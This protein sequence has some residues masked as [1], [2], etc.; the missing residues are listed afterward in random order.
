MEPISFVQIS[1]VHFGTALLSTAYGWIGGY[2]PHAFVLCSALPVAFA[3]AR[4]L[5][6]LGDD[7]PLYLVV[8]GD[9]TA[10]GYA[11]EFAVAHA[12][13]RTRPRIQRS[14]PGN[15]FGLAMPD[16]HLAA[17]P[18]NHDHWRGAPKFRPPPAYSPKTIRAQFRRT[19]WRKRWPSQGPTGVEL[20]GVDSNSGLAGTATN[21]FAK[22]AISTTEFDELDALL[23]ASVGS[24][25]VKAIVCHHSL[26]YAGGVFDARPLDDFSRER[27]LA[28]AAQHRVSAILTGHTHDFDFTR[29]DV[30]DPRSAANI[31]AVWELR[32]AST[33]QGPPK[34]ARQGF[35]LHRIGESG[36]SLRWSSWRYMWNGTHFARA[37]SG[38]PCHEFDIV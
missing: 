17:V 6:G 27:L 38:K 28:I 23:T 35:L 11:C 36:A 15:L 21:T 4:V 19:P 37:D 18:G 34:P 22:G 16:D 29:R 5:T 14:A 33:L 31:R 10:G 13:L 3:D 20:F 9:L 26:S 25:L 30:A 24:G 7:Q 32:S 2:A 8:S 12:F 1:D